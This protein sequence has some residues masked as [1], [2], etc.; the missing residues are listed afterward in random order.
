METMKMEAQGFIASSVPS[1][2]RGYA[3]G[4]DDDEYDQSEMPTI[5]S[6]GNVFGD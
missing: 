5:D 4:G 3:N 1:L 6:N 2:G